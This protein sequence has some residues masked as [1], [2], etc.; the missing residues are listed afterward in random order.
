LY[1]FLD[2]LG[3]GTSPIDGTRIAAAI[4][5][6]M[7]VRR[8][9]GIFA[10]HLHDILGLP[11]KNRERIVEKRMSLPNDEDLFPYTV[12]DGICTDSMALF[13]ARRFGL[14]SRVLERAEFFGEHLLQPHSEPQRSSCF[15]LEKSFPEHSLR[16]FTEIAEKITHC[17]HI[18]VPPRFM[19][20]AR[21]CE[22]QSCVYV[23]EIA[24]EP[25]YYY[26]G[27]SD[28]FHARIEK[29]RR[30]AR[31]G[32][33]DATAIVF[34]MPNKSAARDCEENLIQTMKQAGFPVDNKIT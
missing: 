5:E 28:N 8:V 22:G 2:E 3:R 4:L 6:E 17:K 26:V 14:P 11:L 1:L 15:S 19:P 9:N 23:L 33:K 10:T 21:F 24:T 13:T 16:D 34:P 29:H 12:E 25:P 7:T 30:N 18:L 27:E 20:P 32:W 31:R